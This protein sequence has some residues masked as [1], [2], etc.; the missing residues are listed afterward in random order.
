[1]TSKAKEIN[2]ILG[3][4]DSYQAPSK[5]MEILYSKEKR[6]EVMLEMLKLFN[7]DVSYD[8]FN[9]YF[10]EEHADRK[11][12]KQDFTP[13]SVSTLL[14][15]LIGDTSSGD[16]MFYEGCAGTGSIVISQ[17]N[18]D[19]MQHSPF[20][21][22]PS[23]YLYTLEELSDRAIPFLLF[24]CIIRGMNAVVIH[25]DVLSRRAKGV[26]FIQNDND[27]HMRFSSFNVM[28]YSDD[29]AELSGSFPIEWEKDLV[30]YEVHIESPKSVLDREVVPRGT[31]GMET[32]LL[33]IMFGL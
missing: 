24:N 31:V 12:K 16:G 23:W 30:P 14:S 8:W 2:K 18:S 27:D 22:R 25:C 15:K 13:R 21:Y 7:H 28:P 10:Q 1:M 33:H 6:E 5:L 32:E 9:E 11:E 4:T 3:I 19:R 17:W 26:F 29:V 20:D